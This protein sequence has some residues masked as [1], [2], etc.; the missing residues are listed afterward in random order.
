MAINQTFR[1]GV[2]YFHN[3]ATGRQILACLNELNRTQ[4]LDHDELM[5]LQREKLQWLLDYAYQYVPY[6]R[7]IFAQVGFHPSDMRHDPACFSKLPILTKSLIREHYSE[8]LTTDPQHRKQLSKVTTSGST[9]QPLV[10]MQDHAFRDNVTAD[11]QRHLGWAGWKMGQLHAYM[12]GANFEETTAHTLRNW[13]IDWEWNR[14]LTNAFS[15]TEEKMAAFAERVH[16]QR[17]RILFGYASSLHRFAQFVR[18]GPYRD[19][20]FDGII[21]SAEVLPQAVRQVIEDTFKCRV[22]NR[23]GTKELG[24]VA[25]EC[26]AHNGLH[27]SAENNLIEIECD[28]RQANPGEN[29]SIIVTNLNNWG[30]PFIRYS[31]GDEGA[32]GDESKCSCGRSSPRLKAVEGRIVDQFVTRDGRA[33]WA[34]FAGDAYSSLFAQPTIKQFQIIQESL[35]KISVLLVRDGE[36]PVSLLKRIELALHTAFGEEITVK[37]EFPDHISL[38]PSGKHQYAISKVDLVRETESKEVAR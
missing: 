19:I 35:D 21:S 36:I 11:I 25:C 4:W 16:R 30:M 3:V 37:F 31:I 22:F 33:S 20:T 24:G 38:L 17:P 14:F 26:E 34:G 9:G 29:G 18:Q 32:W 6:Y 27:V 10:L 13:L 2:L 12:W 1:N 15:L 7:R 5:D 8:L 28:G 23:Y